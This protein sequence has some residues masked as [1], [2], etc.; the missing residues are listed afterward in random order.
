LKVA[1]FLTN[2]REIEDLRKVRYWIVGRL[3]EFW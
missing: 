3:K 2:C 1:M